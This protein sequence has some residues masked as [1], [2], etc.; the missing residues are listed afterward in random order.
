MANPLALDPPTAAELDR[1]R[2]RREPRVVWQYIVG[3]AFFLLANI[4]MGIVA[5]VIQVITTG[6]VSGNLDP[7]PSLTIGLFVYAA[8]AVALNVVLVRWLAQRRVLE[9]GR[10]GWAREL[11]LGLLIGAALISVSIGIIALLGGYRVSGVHVGTGILVGLAVGVGAGFAEEIFFR[12]V[13]L[14]LLDKFVG[15][16][17]AVGIVSVLFGLMHVTNGGAGWLGGIAI[18][19]EAGLVLCGAYLLTRRLWLV[20]GIHLGWNTTMASVF[21]SNVSGTGVGTEGL[22]RSTMVGPRWLT[23]G[24]MGM[25][26]SVVTIVVALV[27]GVLM[28]VMAHRRGHLRPR[29]GRDAP[30]IDMRPG[31]DVATPERATGGAVGVND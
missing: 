9:F 29:V 16:L 14:R 5:G 26:G 18:I 12:G 31:L 2:E 30:Q 3:A 4:V 7:W 25:E 23:G 20:V 8:V 21:S 11:G 27:A 1:A 19:I 15:S 13:L 10:S 17:V 28:L 22:L 24:T 6:D